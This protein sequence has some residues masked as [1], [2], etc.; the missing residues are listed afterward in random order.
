MTDPATKRATYADVLAAP[1]D[2]VA[3]LIDGELS[4][5]R[6]PA[7]AHAAA[8]SALGGELVQ[9]FSRGRGGPGGWL[10]VDEPEL[11]LGDDIIVP[12]L[13]GWRREKLPRLPD[14]LYVTLPPDWVGEALSPATARLDRT[15]KRRIYARENVRWLWF[16]EAQ[17]RTLEAFELVE[18]RYAVVDSW[19][20]AAKARIPPFDAF[21][22]DLSVLWEDVEPS[23]LR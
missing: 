2:F 6:R 8:T 20:D 7:M 1:P 18:G 5:Q 15:Q 10:I 22:L 14:A 21:E 3:E 13:A 9:P 19:A 16:I 23:A 11:H 17:A 4:L 12:D